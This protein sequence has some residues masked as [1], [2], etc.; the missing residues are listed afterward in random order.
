MDRSERTKNMIADALLSLFKTKDLN[1]IRIGEICQKCDISRQTFYNHFQDK[2]EL[3]AWIVSMKRNPE[4]HKNVTYLQSLIRYF[5]VIDNNK[6]FYRRL[7]YDPNLS[8]IFNYFVSA[9]RKRI[10]SIVLAENGAVDLDDDLYFYITFYTFGVLYS[11][12]EWVL[13]DFQ[14]SPE[15]I[16]HKVYNAIPDILRPY[17]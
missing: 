7:L 13:N 8:N 6:S 10:G 11:V 2:Y 12:R 14:L 1:E 5:E 15:E 16:A 4:F 17:F 9:N 3:M